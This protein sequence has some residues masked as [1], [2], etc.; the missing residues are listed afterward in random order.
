MSCPTCSGTTRSPIA[1]GYWQCQSLREVRHQ[2]PGFHDITKGPPVVIEH[3][4]CGTRYHD[5][6]PADSAAECSCGTFAIGRCAECRQPVCGLHSGYDDGQLLC[7]TH[8]EE[9]RTRAA[10]LLAAAAADRMAAER[11]RRTREEASGSARVLTRIAHYDDPHERLLLA[12]THW[13]PDLNGYDPLRSFL[14]T[15]RGGTGP[16]RRTNPGENPR[17]PHI[18]T[19]GAGLFATAFP[20]LWPDSEKVV[21]GALD[22]PWSTPALLKWFAARATQHDI[23]TRPVRQSW[24][25]SKREGW[26]FDSAEWHG[27]ER[28]G[29]GTVSVDRRGQQVEPGHLGASGLQT[30]AQRLGLTDPELTW[31]QRAGS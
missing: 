27:G 13:V 18:H 30:M 28:S 7:L 5:G 10:A 8:L 11:N 14:G 6:P 15:H 9:R 20:E 3:L 2:G 17:P 29:Y 1:P 21:L 23:P 16:T 24:S 12:F 25:R 31:P 19:E 4:P 22:P 26:S